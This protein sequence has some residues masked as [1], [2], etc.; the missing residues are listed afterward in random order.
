MGRSI[1]TFRLRPS[2]DLSGL[3]CLQLMGEADMTDTTTVQPRRV[4]AT[5]P[6]STQR[7]TPAPLL[8]LP[9]W[10]VDD[11]T[12]APVDGAALLAQAREGRVRA[13]A[14][15]R[16]RR[17]AAFQPVDAVF[18]SDTFGARIA[19]IQARRMAPALAAE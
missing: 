14:A 5:Q 16:A 15:K 18:A 12:G 6:V 4:R 3:G 1:C 7:P 19:A 17:A 2:G 10:R 9:E 11:P 13:L 8:L